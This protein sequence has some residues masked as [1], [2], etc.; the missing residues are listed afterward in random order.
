MY[1]QFKQLNQTWKS[2]KVK[3]LVYLIL[4]RKFFF[5]SYIKGQLVGNAFKNNIELYNNL[6]SLIQ[7][8]KLIKKIRT[9]IN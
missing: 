6:L 1:Q 3:W 5:N 2:T 4:L 7:A 9:I 8:V